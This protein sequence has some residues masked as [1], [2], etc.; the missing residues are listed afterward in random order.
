[1]PYVKVKNLMNFFVVLLLVVFV[2]ADGGVGDEY[3]T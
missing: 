2:D 1:M 3:V